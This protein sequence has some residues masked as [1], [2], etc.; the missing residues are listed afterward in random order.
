MQLLKFVFFILFL[1]A[2]TSGLSAQSNSGL[3]T[4]KERV[5]SSNISF[6]QELLILVNKTRQRRGLQPVVLH[7]ELTNVA[8][9]HAKDMATDNYFEHDSYDRVAGRKKKRCSFTERLTIFSTITWWGWA[10]N[11]AMGHS[12][13]QAVLK[14]WMKSQ[15]HRVNIMNP[16][17]NY[18]GLAYVKGYWVQT[19]GK[20]MD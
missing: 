14:G 12:S 11:I 3:P 9:Y 5:A 15:G 2:G 20:A 1:V 8:R 19:F 10:E 18:M 13:P 4:G 7:P 6:E 17:Y 16:E